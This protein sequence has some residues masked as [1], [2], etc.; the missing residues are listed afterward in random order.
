[1]NNSEEL[2]CLSICF[3][4]CCL[5]N[6]GSFGKSGILGCW[7]SS[8][9][10]IGIW[11]GF[12]YCFAVFMSWFAF[13]VAVF[14]IS[15]DSF[16]REFYFVILICALCCLF[17]LGRWSF[18]GLCCWSLLVVLLEFDFCVLLFM[19]VLLNPRSLLSV[20]FFISFFAL[21]TDFWVILVCAFVVSFVIEDC[22]LFMVC[23][24]AF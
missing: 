2:G 23:V 5:Y 18:D 20:T 11:L 13:S 15:F 16:F 1:M 21:I 3:L 24:V 19:V 8:G 6:C 17:F 10:F 12:C 7:M 4:R 9:C 14:E 22:C